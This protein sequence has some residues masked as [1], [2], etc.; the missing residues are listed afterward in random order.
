MAANEPYKLEILESIK[1][2]SITIYHIG[3]NCQAEYLLA[4]L[5]DFCLKDYAFSS[6][7]CFSIEIL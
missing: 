6:K 2:E 4:L 7:S 1:D 5:L 3:N